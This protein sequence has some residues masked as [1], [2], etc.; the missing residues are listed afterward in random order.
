[1]SEPQ[2]LDGKPS[3]SVTIS[4][5][6]ALEE[7]RDAAALAREQYNSS[8]KRIRLSL[9]MAWLERKLEAESSSPTYQP[10]HWPN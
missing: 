5:E 6:E 9:A 1:M 2:W 3:Y 8:D 10:E 4:A 7:I